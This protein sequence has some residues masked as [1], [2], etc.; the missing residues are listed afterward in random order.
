MY[1]G[2]WKHWVAHEAALMLYLQQVRREDWLDAAELAHLEQQAMGGS[3]DTFMNWTR[4]FV[5]NRSFVIT[6]RG[7]YG[8]A[9]FTIREGDICAII[10]GTRAPFALRTTEKEGCY[11]VLGNVGITSKESGWDEGEEFFFKLGGQGAQDW[12]EWGLQEED[13]LLI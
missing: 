1:P 11:K 2:N 9:P 8:L 12:L 13:I 7:Y 4:S 5:K 10:F 3:V 6:N